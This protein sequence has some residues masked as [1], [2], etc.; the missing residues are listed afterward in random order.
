[1]KT[2]YELHKVMSWEWFS[3]TKQNGI[4]TVYSRS[5]TAC[6]AKEVQALLR[7]VQLSINP[8]GATEFLK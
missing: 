4:H 2:K 8:C 5:R 3:K 7:V 6:S 1:M